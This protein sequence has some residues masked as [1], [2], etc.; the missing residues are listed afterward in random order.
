MMEDASIEQAIREALACELF[1]ISVKMELFSEAIQVHSMY[2]GILDQTRCIS[3]LIGSFRHA[4]CI[5]QK[6]YLLDQFQLRGEEIQA[7]IET[8]E[9]VAKSNNLGCNANFLRAGL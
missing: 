5:E 6:V 9:M 3:D 2:K 7:L 4:S 1:S 8:F